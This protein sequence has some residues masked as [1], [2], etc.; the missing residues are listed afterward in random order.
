MSHASADIVTPQGHSA[1]SFTFCPLLNVSYCPP[2]TG[3]TTNQVSS[4][5]S[6]SVLLFQEL[7]GVQFL[8]VIVYN[9]LPWTRTEYVRF[10]IPATLSVRVFDSNDQPVTA[11][12]NYGCI[13]T[14]SS[15]AGSSPR[16]FTSQC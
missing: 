11:Q 7:I 15:S 12:V 6:G 10:P 13:F 1:P 14:S 9:H 5:V 16:L 2:T 8:P 4:S 3:L